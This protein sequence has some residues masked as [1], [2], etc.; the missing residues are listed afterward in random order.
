VRRYENILIVAP[1]CAKEEEE[2]LLKRIQA[3]VEKLGAELLKVDDWGVRKLAYSIKKRDRGHYF[4]LLLNMDE[5]TVVALDKFYRTIDLVLRHLFVVVD[6][7]DKGLE[8]PPEP[9]VFDELE[10]EAQ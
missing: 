2:E 6:E 3:N 4:F 5:E 7:K 8:K 1:D 10:G 9:V